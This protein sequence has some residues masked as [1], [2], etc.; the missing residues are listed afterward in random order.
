MK[1]AAWNG[2]YTLNYNYEAPFYAA[3]PTNHVELADSFDQPILDWLP[4]TQALAAKNG[5]GGAYYR[6]HI[7]PLPNGSGDTSEWNQ[8]FNGAFAASVMIA[9]WNATRDV[10]YAGHIYETLKQLA[11]FWQGYLRKDVARWVIDNDAQHEGN[12]N[13]QMNGVMSLGFVRCLLQGTI[14]VATALNVDAPLRDVWKERLANLSAF[15]T[16]QMN[17]K[18]VFRYTEVGLDWN[19]GNA[20][21][22]QHIYP[23]N[24]IGLGSDPTVLA[25]AR[26][27]VDAMAR[28]NDD[29]GT[30]TFYPAAARVGHDPS[31][32][33]TH[34]ASWVSG[35]SY[36]NLHIHTNGGGIENLNTVPSTL[37][38][39][40]LQS[41]QGKLRVFANWPATA[42]ARFG[43]LRAWGAFLVSSQIKA[44]AVQYVRIASERGGSVVLVNPWPGQKLHVYRN[45]ND[46]GSVGGV[47]VAIP[48]AKGDVVSV[49][50]DGTSFA[51]IMARISM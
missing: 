49:A 26:N 29:N 33:L 37:G 46:A 38:E 23:A 3:F 32:I 39:M 8:K 40:L 50:P 9:H 10:A 27:M 22:I 20:I 1:D 25:T 18:T 17:G 24:Q 5:W 43:D 45:G 13:P 47:E 2:D 7:G 31:D 36:P 16:F 11:T 41:F 15:P 35:H 19:G 14:D 6:V 30:N 42:D 21:G 28:W 48:T 51:E 34:L 44:G 12:P 4:N